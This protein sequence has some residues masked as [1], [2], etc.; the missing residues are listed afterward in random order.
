MSTTKETPAAKDSLENELLRYQ[1]E[2]AL[3]LGLQ[4]EQKAQWFDPVPRQ[5]L[6][7]DKASTTI[8]FGGL[9][10]AHDYLVEGALAGLG[11]TVRH[12]DCPDNES[13]RFGKE[14]GNRG[15]C[16]PT[17]FTVGNLIKYLTHLR[18]VEGKSKE[19]IVRNYLFVTSGSC[20]PCRFGTYVTE[21]RKA[22]RD[23]GF[24]GFRVLL[25]QQQSGLKQAT[26]GESALK[27]DS[28]F[29]ISFVKAFLLGDIL[30]A[31][32]YR[33]RPYEVEAG[34][35][36]AVMERCKKILYDALRD[37]KWLIP[38]LIK[39]RKELESIQ[40]DRTRV[41]PKVS[42]IGEFWAMTTEGDGNYQLQRFLEKEGAE[43]DVQ[44]LTAWVLYL[45]WEG[46]YDTMKRMKLRGEDAGRYGLEGKNPVKRLRMLWVADRV[47][48]VMFQTYAKAIGLHDYHLPDMDE[49][50]R[51]AHDH[52]NNHLRGGEGHMEVGKLI[53]NVKKRKVNMTISVKPFGCMPS[54]GVSD[55]V[56]SLITEK[57]PDAIFLPI[58]TTG[59]G[60]INVYS[61]VQMMLFK[62]KQAAQ[63][64][65]DEALAKKGVTANQLRRLM[66]RSSFAHPLQT[67]P[68]VVACTAANAVY[69]LNKYN[70]FFFR[71]NNKVMEEV[72][73]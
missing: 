24:D 27:L 41:K 72:P 13:L 29:F 65:F 45:I 53:L 8:L 22:L 46:R 37:R 62:A 30:N 28:S 10:M 5:F 25:F 15:Q 64:E 38:A 7:K 60:A 11:Y 23:A 48:R 36:D 68:H 47:L 59:D 49:V 71:R 18:D 1:E 17:Y 66:Q 14:F 58:E 16:N 67:S 61:R 44:S 12:M 26:G 50:A 56:Q 57:Y 73:Q 51:V 69:G 2:Q 32:A 20:G 52:Y 42:I 6:A 21:Y 3:A 4:Q 9:T 39:C 33:I 43:V 54:S 55:G 63:K 19:E 70:G 31:L 40:V 34:A 35:T